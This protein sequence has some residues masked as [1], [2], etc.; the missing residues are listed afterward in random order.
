MLGYTVA[1]H[2]HLLHQVKQKAQDADAVLLR[3]DELGRHLRV[4]LFIMGLSGQTAMVRTGWFIANNS[5]T[6]HLTT[7]FV[8]REREK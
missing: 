8:L 3:I 7:L 1:N 5:Q 6:A 4:D 2:E